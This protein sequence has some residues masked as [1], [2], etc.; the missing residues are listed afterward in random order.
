MSQ[1]IA[2]FFALDVHKHYL[3]AGA[4]NAQQEVVLRPR[5]VSLAR[6]PQW[7]SKTFQPT[8]PVVIEATTNARYVYDLVEPL[9]GR[10]LVSHPSNVQLTAASLRQTDHADTPSLPPPPAAHIVPAATR[11]CSSDG[12]G[13]QLSANVGAH[14]GREIH[15]R[16]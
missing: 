14:R 10:A 8:D 9:G 5:R 15:H 4:R 6:F 12:G 1:P 11:D 7:A 3:V 13:G 16:S 2:R